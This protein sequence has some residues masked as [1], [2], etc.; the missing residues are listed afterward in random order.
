[1]WFNL[2]FHFGRSG[3]ERWRESQKEHFKI[4]TDAENHSVTV[5]LTESTKSNTGGHK[6]NSREYSDV[7]MY[8]VDSLPLDPVNALAFYQQK[9]HPGNSNLFAKCKKLFLKLDEIWYTKEVIG[10]NT[11]VNIMKQISGKVGLSQIQ[12]NH[13]VRVSTVTH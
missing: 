1:M 5:V 2:C 4:L 8:E 13:C 6:Q 9:L 3:R 10:K 11:L 7:R 12:K